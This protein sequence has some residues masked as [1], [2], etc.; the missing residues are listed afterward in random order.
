MSK[1]QFK[2]DSVKKVKDLQEK[3]IQKEIALID[4]E[5]DKNITECEKLKREAE[6]NLKNRKNNKISELKAIENYRRLLDRNIDTIQKNIA[7]LKK[8]R[9]GKM[10][11]LI[12]KSK[13]SKIFKTLEENHLENFKYE[14]NLKDENRINEIATQKFIRDKA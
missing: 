2:Y 10:Y 13:E 12:T 9:E 7:A 6:N 8:K 5:I 14:E 4:I 1:F 3:K 11:E